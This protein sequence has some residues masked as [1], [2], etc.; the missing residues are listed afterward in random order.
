MH[1]IHLNVQ[2]LVTIHK[3]MLGYK[4]FNVETHKSG[5]YYVASK[6]LN[7]AARMLLSML[8]IKENN[9]L[10][11]LERWK[12]ARLMLERM[13]NTMMLVLWRYREYL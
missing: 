6:L 3:L 7:R 2:T 10:M 5:Y 4:L 12:R 8:H 9:K 13:G 1:N 11:V